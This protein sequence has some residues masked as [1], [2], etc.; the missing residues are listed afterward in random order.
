MPSRNGWLVA[1]PPVVKTAARLAGEHRPPTPATIWSAWTFE[2]GA[3]IGIVVL[4]VAYWLG[5]R[6][7]WARAGAGRGVPAWRPVAFV[8]GMVSLALA[9][10]SPLDALATALFSAHMVQHLVLLVVV[11]PLLV[12]GDWGRGVLW[13]L[14]RSARR[15]LAGFR[16]RVEPLT[17]PAPSWALAAAL[18]W[19]WHLPRLYE[20]ALAHEGIHA[21][22]H[23]TLLGASLLFWRVLFRPAG[24]R[25][26]RG[27]GILYLFAMG[28][29][30]SALGA[31]LTFATVPW[32]PSHRPWTTAF[33][34][35]PLEDQQLAGLL[36][37]IPA[38]LVYLAAAAVLFL[39]WLEPGRSIAR[40]DRR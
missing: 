2:P 9:L 1:I 26:D 36:M 20:V 15:R 10:V 23:I 28:L 24:V 3:L 27:A 22:E 33:G 29:Q 39:Q 35:T 7:L 8:G 31:L 13:A 16:D 38:G 11:A 37:W 12:L 40:A 4:G 18:L 6:R 19:L 17:R 34:L 5:I 21:L 25:I 32:Y 30:G 14:P